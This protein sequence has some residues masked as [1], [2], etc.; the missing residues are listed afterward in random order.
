MITGGASGQGRAAALRFSE[1][2]ARIVIADVDD[3]GSAE[4]VKLV[5]ERGGEALALHADVSRTR[6]QR[7][8]D[9]RRRRAVGAAG[10]PLQQRRRPDVRAAA[11]VH[12]GRLGPDD[13]HEPRRHLLG[14]P[15]RHPPDARGW[16]RV[17]H[18]HRVGARPG[19]VRRATAPTAPPRPAW[20]RSP[21]RSRSSTARRSAPTS[22]R[23]ARST[24]PASRRSPRRWAG[25]RGVPRRCST[26]T[27]RCTGSGTADDVAG[28]ALFLAS[29]QSAYTTGA[30]I[31]ADG[32]LAALR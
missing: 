4:T 21:G 24:P 11:R 28:I 30:V 26:R 1:A 20:W 25:A 31:P 8:D 19:R 18:Q 23:P 15:G 16:R 7:G 3:A 6:R 27:S 13:G 29:E 32:G 10:R 5:E 2:G 12:G 14:L 17:D 22:S 9:R